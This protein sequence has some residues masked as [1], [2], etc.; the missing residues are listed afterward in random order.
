MKL[1]ENPIFFTQKRLVHRGGVLAAVLIAA[2]IGLSLLAG[3]V[4]YRAIPTDFRGFLT[5]QEAGKTF[6]AWT[7]AA[8]ILVLVIGGF[9]RVSRT[10]AE[11]RKAGLWDSNRLTPLQPSEIITGY[12]LG[13]ALR[14][15]YM[16]LTCL[17]YTSPSP[18][19]GLLSRMPSSA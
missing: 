11:E 15:I 7:I 10:L 2:L 12:W 16:A 8:E 14:E 17:L 9:S 5:V 1:N 18:R 3:L 4:A 13:S 19:D 6:Y